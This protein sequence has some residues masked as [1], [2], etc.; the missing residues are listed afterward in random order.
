M[1]RE[2]HF[3]AWDKVDKKFIYLMLC[4]NHYELTGIEHNESLSKHDLEDW[5]QFTGLKD[6]NGVEIYEGD[7]VHKEKDGIIWSV[8]YDETQA[9]FIVFNQLNS[10][11]DFDYDLNT[12]ETMVSIYEGNTFYPEVI[13]NIYSNPELLKI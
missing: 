6:K 1:S 11:R 8:E 12:G 9:K 13:G 10:D 2:I 3:R 5:Q 7:I 4:N